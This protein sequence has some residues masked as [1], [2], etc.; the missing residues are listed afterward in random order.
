MLTSLL[1]F[2][3]I[4]ISGILSV[5]AYL[6][7]KSRITYYQRKQLVTMRVKKVRVCGKRTSN[8]SILTSRKL[9][10]SHNTR[11]MSRKNFIVI[12]I[13]LLIMASLDEMSRGRVS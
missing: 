8:T 7:Q 12:R 5:M 11:T 4:C 3:S 9:C 2:M 1:I 6:K 13:I 10:D